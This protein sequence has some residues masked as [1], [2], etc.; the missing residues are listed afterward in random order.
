MGP[1]S[2]PTRWFADRLN[3]H[4]LASGADGQFFKMKL[5]RFLIAFHKIY[6]KTMVFV[7][8]WQDSS[9]TK[10][11]AVFL[12][13]TIL[14]ANTEG[15]EYWGTF[16]HMCPLIQPFLPC[17]MLIPRTQVL[18]KLSVNYDAIHPEALET[19]YSFLIPHVPC[20]HPLQ[21]RL[22][23][24]NRNLTNKPDSSP[25]PS[26]SLCC[27]WCWRPSRTTRTSQTSLLH[28]PPPPKS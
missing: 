13:R 24:Q 22:I 20:D 28:Q 26:G 25:S 4:E 6:L 14:K 18:L 2:L 15:K 10:E 5:C 3:L 11:N 21:W 16:L 17:H 9:V 12:P 1:I 23:S 7:K 27:R 19:R 8:P